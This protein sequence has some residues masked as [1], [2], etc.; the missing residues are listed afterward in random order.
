MRSCNFHGD[1]Q[2][3]LQSESRFLK[4]TPFQTLVQPKQL[5]GLRTKASVET[6]NSYVCKFKYEFNQLFKLY[7]LILQLQA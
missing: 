2:S 4:E 7:T 5:G 1:A 3:K 6:S